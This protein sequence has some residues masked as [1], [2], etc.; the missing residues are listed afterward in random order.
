MGIKDNKDKMRVELD[1]SFIESMAQRMDANKDKYPRDNWK[2]SI[3]ITELEDALMRH[4]FDYK[5]G[6]DKEN[7]LAA[8]ALNAMMIEYQRKNN[9]LSKTPDENFDSLKWKEELRRIQAEEAQKSWKDRY[10][11][12]QVM[13]SAS[14][15]EYIG[16]PGGVDNK[17][18]NY[19][20][21]INTYR[22]KADKLWEERQG[23]EEYT[24]FVEKQLSTAKKLWDNPEV[25][26]NYRIDNIN[27]RLEGKD[28]NF[29]KSA[30]TSVWVDPPSG[31]RYG[32]PKQA[33]Y[34]LPDNMTDWIIDQGYPRAEVE[35]LGNHFHVRFTEIYE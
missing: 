7:H 3:D 11:K 13:Y 25:R 2:N 22:D 17:D 10:P 30:P 27:N 23:N 24:K 21:Y 6:D 15:E 29:V 9:S 26:L 28:N 19:D 18:E 1:W 35:N 8:I 5:R 16:A 20:Y 14:D 4:W 32:F 33:P 12:D 34:P 31:W